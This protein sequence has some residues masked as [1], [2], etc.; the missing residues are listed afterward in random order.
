MPLPAGTPNDPDRPTL[1]EITAAP[2]ATML[3][4][5]LELYNATVA[6][7]EAMGVGEGDRSVVAFKIWTGGTHGEVVSLHRKP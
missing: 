7:P 4:G 5:A 2:W 1:V 6:T 3:R